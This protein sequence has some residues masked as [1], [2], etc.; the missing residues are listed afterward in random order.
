MIYRLMI[1]FLV[2]FLP[3]HAGSINVKHLAG[4][5][6]EGWGIEHT[7]N[8]GTMAGNVYSNPCHKS[9]NTTSV[10]S[11]GCAF[12]VDIIITSYAVTVQQTLAGDPEEGIVALRVDGVVRSITQIEVGA[13]SSTGRCDVVTPVG[14]ASTTGPGE[15]CRR[16]FLI[17]VAAGTPWQIDF[18]ADI[19]AQQTVLHSIRGVYQ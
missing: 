18:D 11:D 6:R 15:S 9:N 14:D 1:A 2:L 13:G 5:A 12:P 16:N 10:L 17:A 8:D 19:G 3:S 4:T 7:V